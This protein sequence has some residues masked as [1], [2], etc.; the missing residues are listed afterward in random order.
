MGARD[1]DEVGGRL[2]SGLLP[3]AAASFATLPSGVWSNG[4][5][6]GVSA[7]G[8]HSRRR[9]LPANDHGVV[10]SHLLNLTYG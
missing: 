9:L 1:D 4:G 10:V 3:E 8:V 7:N 2:W 6:H 5:T